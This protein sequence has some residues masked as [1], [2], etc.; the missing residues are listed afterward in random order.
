MTRGA[1][2][3]DPPFLA[4]MSLAPYYPSK[5]QNGITLLLLKGPYYGSNTL[6]HITQTILQS[7]QNNG[8]K[9]LSEEKRKSPFFS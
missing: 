8:G 9:N 3:L 1:R 7:F 4:A 2:G 6:E 5:P